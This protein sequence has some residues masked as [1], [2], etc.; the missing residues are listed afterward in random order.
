[1]RKG[2]EKV[3][4]KWNISM[5]LCDTDVPFSVGSRKDTFLFFKITKYSS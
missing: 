5:V 3:Y 1:M 4:D 2:P